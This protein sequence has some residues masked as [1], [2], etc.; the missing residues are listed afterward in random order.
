MDIEIATVCEAASQYGGRLS[1]LGAMSRIVTN[2][3]PFAVPQCA[4]VLRFRFSRIE[5]GK[6]NIKIQF[7]DDDGNPILPPLDTDFPVKLEGKENFGYS[8]M[9]M[10]IHNLKFEKPGTYSVD[11]AVDGRQEKSLPLIVIQAPGPFPGKEQ[12]DH[13]EKN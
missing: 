5:S 6:H 3:F 8:D 10:N 2:Q 1:I 12:G 13:Y 4:V 9:V 11:V 7:V